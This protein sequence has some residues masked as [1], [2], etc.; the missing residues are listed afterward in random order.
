MQKNRRTLVMGL[1]AGALAAASG[2]RAQGADYPSKPVRIILPLAAG[3]SGDIATRFF[4]E[5]LTQRLG[6]SF[7]VDNLP[8][9]NALPAVAALNRSAH[10]GY[11]LLQGTSAAVSLNPVLV[12]NLPYDALE[13]LKPVAGLIRTAQVIAVPSTSP[14]RT[15]ADV[16]KTAKTAGN[17]LN[18][19][20]YGPLYL[21]A[22][23]WFGSVIGAKFNNI[24]YKGANEAATALAA[25]QL[26]MG[27]VDF[28]GVLPLVRAGRIRVVA[29]TSDERLADFPDVPTFRESGYP[30]FVSYAWASLY[31]RREVPDA[32]V[33]KLAV[34]M[35]A[36]HGSKETRDFVG[37][38]PGVQTMPF[39][40]AEMRKFQVEEINRLRKIATMANIQPQ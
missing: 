25:G 33:D 11:T 18:S 21:L 19:A 10:D 12:K 40:P 6:Q 24:A 22:Q 8:G 2:A 38:Q 39:G 14:M 5:R 3:S 15:L 34:A 7:I 17:P 37:K 13:D 4:A 23:E 32:V 28:A 31:V 26:D 16:V 1:G 35:R 20:T 29:V 27:F 9:A 36:V 30:D